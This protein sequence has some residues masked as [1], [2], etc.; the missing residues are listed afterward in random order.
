VSSCGPGRPG[1]NIGAEPLTEV[2]SRTAFGTL[3]KERFSL[4][5]PSA[6]TR[7]CCIGL[8]PQEGSADD[9]CMSF[10]SLRLQGT[11]R[12]CVG[13]A[14]TMAEGASRAMGIGVCIW[15]G[16]GPTM[17]CMDGPPT[18]G[19]RAD[20]RVES[21]ALSVSNGLPRPFPMRAITL[22][23]E[24]FTPLFTPRPLRCTLSPKTFLRASPDFLAARSYWKRCIFLHPSPRQVFEAQRT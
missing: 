20:I 5:A 6:L 15:M 21:G 7:G 19:T 22:F 13:G 2:A 23:R 17:G 18:A 9:G 16:G 24:S 10:E 11:M 12:P 14:G 3:N 1:S 4:T 8:I